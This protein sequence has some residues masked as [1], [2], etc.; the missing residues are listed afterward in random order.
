VAVL[1][2]ALVIVTA[3]FDWRVNM[4]KGKGKSGGKGKGGKGKC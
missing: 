4:A 2:V 3:Y 1:M